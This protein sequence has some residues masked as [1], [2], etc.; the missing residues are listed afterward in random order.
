MMKLLK[1]LIGTRNRSP[2]PVVSV[3]AEMD[4]SDIYHGHE[5]VPALS[6]TTPLRVLRLA[7]VR[8]NGRGKAPI[9]YGE[10][11]G[12]YPL[13]GDGDS[14]MQQKQS[15]SW[16]YQSAADVIPDLIRFREALEA[17]T[18]YGE[19]REAVRSA[20]AASRALRGMD[21]DAVL[22][23][24]YPSVFSLIPGVNSRVAGSLSMAYKTLAD[25]ERAT[26]EELLRLPGVGKKTLTTIRMNL[27]NAGCRMDVERVECIER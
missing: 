1:L 18:P 13:I 5:F 9:P 21:V 8:W 3:R 6:L 2:Q 19:K 27:G 26:D 11:G 25:V 16:G 24:F 4:G 14:M 22:D 10:H 15:S 23:P 7:G 12:W 17:F 20:L